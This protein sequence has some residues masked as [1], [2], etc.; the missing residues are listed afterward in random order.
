[1]KFNLVNDNKLQIIISKEDMQ[2]RE[3]SKWDLVPHNPEAQKLFQEILEEAR[4]ACGFDVGQNAQLMIEAYP[5]TGESMIVTVTKIH[6]GSDM[7]IDLGLEGIGQALMDEL[8]QEDIPEIVSEE[9]VVRF[10]QM[11]DVIQVSALLRGNYDGASQLLRYE[12][13]YFLALLEKEW[14]TDSGAAALLEFGDE[15]S[16]SMEFFQE[17]GQMIIAENA[18]EILSEL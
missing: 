13:N 18:L 8:M 10:A 9:V 2:Q 1:M 15:V 16:V 12:D 5:M 17:H 6:S 11:E 14:L 3:I 4:D 7:P